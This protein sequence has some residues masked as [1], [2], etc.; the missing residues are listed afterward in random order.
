MKIN[1]NTLVQGKIYYLEE[2][3][4][5][6]NN[7]DSSYMVS[8]F[9]NVHALAEVTLFE[10]LLSVHLSIKG[11]AIMISAY[12]LQEGEWKINLKENLT[13]TLTEEN[14]DEEMIYLSK[15]N[16]ELD[17]YIRSLVLASLPTKFIKKG[18]KLPQSGKDYKV[19]SEEEFHIAR[20]KKKSSPFDKLDDIELDE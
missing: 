3:I 4:S 15:N 13:F 20:S 10:D 5:F 7:I 12:S 14:E 6:D 16:L 2:D 11:I 17:D 8:R 19:M 18:E 1:I 9:E